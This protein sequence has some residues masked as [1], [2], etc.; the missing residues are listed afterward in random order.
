[1]RDD[2]D[3]TVFK[4]PLPGG[5]RPGARPIPRQRALEVEPGPLTGSNRIQQD[6]PPS[7]ETPSR[8]VNGADLI[9]FSTRGGLN[10]LVNAAATILAVFD[11]TRGA[12]RH[13]DV[14]GLHRRLAAEIRRTEALIQLTGDILDFARIESEL[15]A[16]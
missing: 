15:F 10:P 6:P 11:K 12:M 5:D 1:M 16:R 7:T 2:A 8:P 14:A 9:R 13:P 4:Y 3:N